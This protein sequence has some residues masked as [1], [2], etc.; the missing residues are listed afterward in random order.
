[1]KPLRSCEYEFLRILNLFNTYRMMV[2]RPFSKKQ[3][4]ETK[5]GWGGGGE[6][7]AFTQRMGSQSGVQPWGQGGLSNLGS[8]GKTAHK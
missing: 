1:M 7:A 8:H 3:V 5:V 2:T 4:N 6:R